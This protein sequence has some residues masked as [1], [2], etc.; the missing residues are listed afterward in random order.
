[1]VRETCAGAGAQINLR[2]RACR[3]FA[4]TGNEVGMKVRLDDVGNL[5][6]EPLRFLQIDFDVALR[7][8][9]RRDSFRAELVRCVRQAAEVELLKVHGP[10]CSAIWGNTNSLLEASLTQRRGPGARQSPS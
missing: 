5:Q 7:V 8:H 2:A 9:H 3:E 10:P 6:L 4:V 1:M